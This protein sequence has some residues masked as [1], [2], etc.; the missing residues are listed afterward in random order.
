MAKNRLI[1]IKGI[2]ITISTINEQDY[3]SLTDMVKGFEDGTAAIERWLRAKD[4]IE[5]IGIWEVY[6]NPD[7]NS[8]EFEGIKNAAGTNR[9][10]LTRLRLASAVESALLHICGIARTSFLGERQRCGTATSESRLRKQG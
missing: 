4:T 3:F 10:S 7:F 2:P 9:F 8:P 5:F 1:E 6:N